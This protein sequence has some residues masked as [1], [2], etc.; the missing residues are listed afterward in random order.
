VCVILS[1][2]QALQTR[3]NLVQTYKQEAKCV[4]Y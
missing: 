1:S 2:V 4:S 3:I